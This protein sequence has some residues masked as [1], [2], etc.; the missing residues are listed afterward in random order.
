MS[1]VKTQK[2]AI[3]FLSKNK[4]FKAMMSIDDL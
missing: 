3:F 2:N 1:V 4:Q